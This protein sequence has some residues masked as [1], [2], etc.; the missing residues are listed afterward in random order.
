M[1]FDGQDFFRTKVIAVPDDVLN[2]EII[3][4]RNILNRCEI[5]ING[6]IEYLGSVEQFKQR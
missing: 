5:N 4:D 2:S 1:S 3:I 6:Q